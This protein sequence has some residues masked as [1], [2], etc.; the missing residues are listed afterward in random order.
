MAIWL[1]DQDKVYSYQDIKAL[2]KDKE[3][4]FILFEVI[5]SVYC[6]LSYNEDL[7]G[8][9]CLDL[10]DHGFTGNCWYDNT[11]SNYQQ[12]T[13]YKLN[14]TNFKGLLTLAKYIQ[15]DIINNVDRK[16]ELKLD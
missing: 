15:Q 12:N 16:I 9:L 10:F 2:P 11:R 8:C 7:N 5:G 4:K 6:A 3:Y 14:K 1:E 13:F